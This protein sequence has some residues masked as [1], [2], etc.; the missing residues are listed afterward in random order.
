MLVIPKIKREKRKER[1]TAVRNQEMNTKN[2]PWERNS[3]VLYDW[4]SGDLKEQD[5]KKL[6]QRLILQ[7]TM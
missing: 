4:S 3:H 2:R 1:T 6:D 7:D 5:K